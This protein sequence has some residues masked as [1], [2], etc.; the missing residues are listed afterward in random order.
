MEA[1]RR[2]AD[3]AIELADLALDLANTQADPT[4]RR[5]VHPLA[6]AVR[7]L[8]LAVKTLDGKSPR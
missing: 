1:I 5:V 4:F 8:A 2:A 6:D 7:V 3:E